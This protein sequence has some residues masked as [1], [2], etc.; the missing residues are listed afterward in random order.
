[1]HT[2]ASHVVALDEP[3]ID[4]FGVLHR[5]SQWVALPPVEERL[6]GELMRRAGFVVSRRAL[7]R[8][9]WPGGAPKE[10]SIDSRI[11]LL[12]RRVSPLGVRIMTVRGQGFVLE[13]D[14]RVPDA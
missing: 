3:Y 13:I 5:G 7:A 10:R 14:E 2:L 12:R 4:E 8:A 9:A 11:L 1:M 6:A